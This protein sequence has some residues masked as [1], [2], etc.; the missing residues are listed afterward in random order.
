MLELI[1]L[2]CGVIVLFYTPI[3]AKKVH[4][5]W[6][7]PKFKGTPEE[8]RAK[9]V[10]QLKVVAWIGF[11]VGPLYA[12]LGI[13]LG[14]S[15]SAQLIVKLVIGGLWIAVGVVNLMMRRKYFETPANVGPV[16]RQ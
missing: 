10:R 16:N 3:E 14:G 13:A 12:I 6:V 8:F 9:Y 5:G 2:V 1:I 4:G 7:R 15:N 11:I